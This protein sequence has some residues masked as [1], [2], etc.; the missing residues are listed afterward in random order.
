M[1]NCEEKSLKATI[2][3]IKRFASEHADAVS[4]YREIEALGDLSL[5]SKSFKNDEKF[6]ERVNY[7]IS[8]IVTIIAHPHI[9]NVREDIIIRA[10]QAPALTVDMF[11]RTVKDTKLWRDK[12][13]EMVPEEVYYYQNVDEIK[14][15]ENRFIVH[16]ID[17]LSDRLAD[18]SAFYSFLI[19]TVN[20][21]SALSQKNSE[22]EKSIERLDSLSKKIRRLKNT[23]FY[24]EVSKRS[25]VTAMVQ[26][27]NVLLKNRHYLHCFRFYLEY[28]TY[29]SRV[30]LIDDIK[31]Y[32]F[33]HLLQALK[34]AGY[35]LSQQSEM[36]MICYNNTGEIK[37]NRPL[38]F[39]NETFILTVDGAKEYGG[40]WF[41][42]R[43][44]K[45]RLG[46]CNPAN[47]LLLF[48]GSV[49]FDECDKN[50]ERFKNSGAMA[51]DALSPWNRA[52]INAWGA[53]PVNE[54]PVPEREITARYIAEKTHL[55]PASQTIYETHCPVC[56][57]R[58]ITEDEDFGIFTCGS[59]NTKYTFITSTNLKQIWFINLGIK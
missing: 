1:I 55:M 54:N 46:E 51:I 36:E 13:G 35:K 37:F 5:Q 21:G 45:V 2:S 12:R 56:R 17:V 26:P 31:V 11:D 59:C 50:T 14:T 53:E 43:N 20:G 10:E 8:V 18:Y 44:K 7:L 40:L 30:A 48:D 28:I 57:G 38:S 25:W 39:V 22:L 9:I 24:R 3:K 16:L 34:R 23:Y 27:T 32:Y 6:F 41:R 42:V 4:F 52:K 33:T 58:N 19:G 49:T 15:Y 47:H 29:G